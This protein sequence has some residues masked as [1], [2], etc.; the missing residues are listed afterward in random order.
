MA[1][2]ATTMTMPKLAWHPTVYRELDRFARIAKGRRIR[3]RVEFA[4]DVIVIPEGPFKDSHWRPHFQ[5]Y[6]YHLLNAMDTLKFRKYRV[7]G[8]VQSGKTF[9]VPVINTL[10]HLFELRQTVVFGVP[11]META[12]DKWREELLPAIEASPWLRQFLPKGGKGSRGGVATSYKFMNG[13]TLRFMSATGGDHRRSHYTTPVVVKTEVDRY[14]QSTGLSREASPVEQM[15]AR[16]EAFGDLAYS[17]EECTVTTETGR[18]WSELQRGTNTRLFV[19]CPYCAAWVYPER[20]DFVGIE[21][22]ETVDSA[23]ELGSFKCPDCS[24]LWSQR[25]RRKMLSIDCMIPVHRGQKI[26]DGKAVGPMPKTD[27]M[28]FSWN[29]FHNAFWSTEKIAADEWN[30]IYSTHPDEADLKRRQFAW[31]L[32]SEPEEFDITPLTIQ[33]ILARRVEG[34]TL[35][36]VPPNTTHLSCGLDVGKRKLHY[37][38]RAWTKDD[39]NRVTGHRIDMGTIDVESDSIGF[40]DA[41]PQAFFRFLEM[42]IRPGYRDAK[43]VAYPVAFTLID[44]GWQGEHAREEVIWSIIDR[45]RTEKI[46]GVLM[47]LGRGQSEPPGAG[48]YVHPK[49]SKKGKQALWVGEQ[50]FVRK[51]DKYNLPYMIHNSDHWKSFVHAGCEAPIGSNGSLSHFEPVTSEEKE[52]NRQHAKQLLSEKQV[53]R[54]VTGRGQVQCWEKN[55]RTANHYF[56]ADAYSCSAANFAGVVISQHRYESPKIETKLQPIETHDGRAFLVSNRTE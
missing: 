2:I 3:S 56:D 5:P 9:S 28:S 14:D 37:V 12:G 47:V 36:V 41:G 46:K 35:G 1:A 21:D 50:C 15:E 40:R 48:S 32:P 30:A 52:L 17:Y 43:G 26:I 39:Q 11:E 25:E 42:R 34:L 16:T 51:N 38:V 49:G 55:N 27:T 29:A 44:G 22:C 4:R 19:Q 20:K 7:T 33:D 10:W 24:A 13:S 23:K 54:F 31:A 18:I 8:C 53:S 45:C 6:S